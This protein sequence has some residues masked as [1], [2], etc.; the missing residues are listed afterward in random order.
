[1]SD[2]QP[3]VKLEC[4]GLKCDAPGCGYVDKTVELTP[5]TVMASIGKPCPKCGASL[6]TAADAANTL[7]IQG[8]VAGVNAANVSKMVK[9]AKSGK[10]APVKHI[11]IRWTAAARWT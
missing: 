4:L 9:L 6:L 2:P 1:M 11:A 8:L 3:A 5:D 10:T 7:L